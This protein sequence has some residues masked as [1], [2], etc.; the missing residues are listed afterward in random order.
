MA[1]TTKYYKVL[2]EQFR[3][4]CWYAPMVFRRSG[5]ADPVPSFPD[6]QTT[7]GRVR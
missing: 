2:E 6:T 5:K 4:G 7:A 1:G 3:V